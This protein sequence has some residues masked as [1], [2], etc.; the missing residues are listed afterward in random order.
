MDESNNMGSLPPI[1]RVR[2]TQN[3]GIELQQVNNNNINVPQFNPNLQVPQFNPNL[4]KQIVIYGKTYSTTDTKVLST[5]YS[6]DGNSY[7]GYIENNEPTSGTLIIKDRYSYKGNF[8]NGLPEGEGTFRFQDGSKYTGSIKD[9]RYNGTGTWNVGSMKYK[10][11]WKNGLLD[12]TGTR[13]WKEDWEDGKRKAN[14]NKK[15]VQPIIQNPAYAE[16]PNLSYTVQQ[17]LLPPTINRGNLIPPPGKNYLLPPAPGKK[18]NESDLSVLRIG[19]MIIRRDF[20]IATNN[21]LGVN[22]RN[23][24]AKELDIGITKL[25]KPIKMREI[26][27]KKKIYSEDQGRDQEPNNVWSE[28]L[29]VSY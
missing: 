13:M 6:K 20:P 1:K 28:S 18:N 27:H 21:N 9:G 5:Y 24:A 14:D 8:K 26:N 17:P 29:E 11:S 19:N 4:I 15:Q 7:T 10:G 16:N 3:Q 2:K 23:Q 25:P 12:G 22:I